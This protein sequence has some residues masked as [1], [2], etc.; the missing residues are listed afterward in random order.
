MIM[1]PSIARI[2]PDSLGFW[3]RSGEDDIAVVVLMRPGGGIMAGQAL[4]L[5]VCGAGR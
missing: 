3:L 5:L 4:Q 2:C 1:N